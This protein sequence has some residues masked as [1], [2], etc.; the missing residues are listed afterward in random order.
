MAK[1]WKGPRSSST[2]EQIKKLC[3]SQVQWLLATQEAKIR[4]IA[5]QSQPRANS[6]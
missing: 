4:R 5:L 1:I 3:V 2:G 6:S